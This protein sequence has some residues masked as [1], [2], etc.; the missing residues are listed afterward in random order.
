MNK[1]EIPAGGIVFKEGEMNNAMYVILS[2]SVEVFFTRKNIVQ[3]LAVMNKGDFFGEMA[4][5]RAR[6]R[7]ATAKAILDCQLAVIESKQQLEKFLI[8]N[9]DF[10]AKMVRILADRLANTDELLGSTLEEFCE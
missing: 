3:R 7:T 4:L 1:M 9:P 6:P 2:G 10:S 5:F 8:K